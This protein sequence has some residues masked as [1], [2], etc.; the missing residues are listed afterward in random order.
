MLACR[1]LIVES[2]EA[3]ILARACLMLEKIDDVTTVRNRPDLVSFSY[4]L[5]SDYD[6][7]L[8]APRKALNTLIY[9]YIAIR[10]PIVLE[11]LL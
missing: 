5:C 2:L 7:I 3:L 9:S 11:A 4:W 10:D 6:G 8:G 1:A